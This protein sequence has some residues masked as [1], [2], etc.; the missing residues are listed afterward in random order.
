[1]A[2]FWC[3][4][5]VMIKTEDLI[6]QVSARSWWAFHVPWARKL[7]AHY[8]EV[9][10][11]SNGSEL[12]HLCL[13]YG[14]LHLMWSTALEACNVMKSFQRRRLRLSEVVC[15]DS[16]WNGHATAFSQ[17]VHPFKHL[18]LFSSM[19]KASP[20]VYATVLIF[21]TKCGLCLHGIYLNNGHLSKTK[22]L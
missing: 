14:K 18:L 3:W 2:A 8:S 21:Q 9:H 17:L 7:H 22:A 11:V 6:K 12:C 16:A 13:E 1:M 5:G 15:A 20:V 10:K 4:R 19:A